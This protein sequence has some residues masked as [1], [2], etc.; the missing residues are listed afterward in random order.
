MHDMRSAQLA[1]SQ[2]IVTAHDQAYLKVKA[3]FE[4]LKGQLAP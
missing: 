4:Q 3:I 1:K 2:F